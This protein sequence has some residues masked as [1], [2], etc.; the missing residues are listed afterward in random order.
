[1]K[2][3]GKQNAVGKRPL[4]SA[5]AGSKVSKNYNTKNEPVVGRNI[6]HRARPCKGAKLTPWLWTGRTKE[7]RTQAEMQGDPGRYGR[8]AAVDGW[9]YTRPCKAVN[10]DVLFRIPKTS[11][12]CTRYK[13]MSILLVHSSEI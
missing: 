10:N 6:F 1:L 12:F 2:S 9:E 3:N 8:F 5:I 11:Y 13:E 4:K 7:V